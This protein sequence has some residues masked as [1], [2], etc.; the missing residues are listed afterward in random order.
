MRED[1]GI[2]GSACKILA[3]AEGDM[4]ALRVLI[5]LSQA[6][7]DDVDVV[8]GSL[9]ATDQKVVRLDITMD[10]PLFVHLLN[11]VNLV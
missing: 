1:G 3:L 7:I 11:A 2:P 6:K 10:D 8:L 9:I 4:L 5:A